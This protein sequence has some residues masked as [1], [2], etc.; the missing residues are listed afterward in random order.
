MDALIEKLVESLGGSWGEIVD[1]L[2]SQNSIEEIANRIARGDVA[3]AVAGLAD[4]ADRYAGGVHSAF[5]TAAGD[6]Q[7][8][9]DGEVDGLVTY[10]ATNTRAIRW[11]QTQ[12]LRLRGAITQDQTDMIRT[13]IV[14]GIRS[15]LNPLDTAQVIRNS[16]GLTGSQAQ[17]VDNYRRALQAQDWDNAL[18]RQ[19]TSGHSDR[20]VRAASVADRPLT[21]QQ[22]DTAVDRYREN[23]IT[24]R[25][26]TI[27]RTESLRAAHAGTNEMY[28]QAIDDGT[29]AQNDLV[30]TWRTGPRTGKDSPRPSH[31]AMDGQQQPVGSDF[32]SGL[33]N[34]L[35]YP[36]DPRAPAE[37]VVN[38]RC[39]ISTTFG[40]VDKRRKRA[41]VTYAPPPLYAEIGRWMRTEADRAA[42]ED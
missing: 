13:A 22:I 42:W 6:A 10:D 5:N 41:A 31:A 9:L 19:L 25:A 15:G 4:A 12:A 11:A 37:D 17:I 38:C 32:T 39:V 35:A 16:I 40:S 20:S 36:G 26:E 24:F 18:S 33:G 34:A 30:Q 28:Q 1:W 23:W 8:W 14:D 21:Q 7:K 2:R 3:G 29:L 27:A